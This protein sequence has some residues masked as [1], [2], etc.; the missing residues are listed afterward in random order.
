MDLEQYRFHKKMP[1]EPPIKC[2]AMILNP[3]RLKGAIKEIESNVELFHTSGLAHDKT[4]IFMARVGK[5]IK[6]VNEKK[7]CQ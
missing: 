7:I 4:I 6:P 2:K 5:E 1:I 3:S